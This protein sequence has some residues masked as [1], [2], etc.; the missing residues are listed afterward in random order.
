MIVREAKPEDNKKLLELER[1]TYQGGWLELVFEKKDFFS[2]AS[3]FLKSKIFVIEE[4]EELVG[5]ISA[6]VK[7]VLI[8]NKKYLAGALFDLR[9]NSEFRHKIRKEYYYIIRKID[10]W[11]EDQ[12]VIL[13]YGYIRIDN[14]AA[15]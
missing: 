11:L 3:R 12:N 15:L 14:Q 13:S 7:E 8:N 6:G 2:K 4:N 1:T 5:T 9:L 10:K